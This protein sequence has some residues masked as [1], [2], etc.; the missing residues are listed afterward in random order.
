MNYP[1]GEPTTTRPRPAEDRRTDPGT[2][3]LDATEA[4]DVVPD[5]HAFALCLT[6]DV[7]RPYYTYQSVADA[8]RRRSATP[9]RR[10]VTGPNPYWQ[11]DRIVDL[12]SELGVRSS[13][14]FLR[15]PP[16]WR[17]GGPR[18]WLDPTNW[19]EHLGRY[20]VAAPALADAVRTLDE[21]GWEV[22]LHGSRRAHRDR[23]RLAAEKRRLETVLGHEVA[24]CR[25]H[26]LALSAATWAHQRDVGLRYDATLGSATSVGFAHGYAP[27]RPA[28]DDFLVFPLTAMEVAL[29]DPGDDFAGA[30]AACDRLCEEAASNDA[31]ATVLWH[32]RYFSEFAFPGYRRLYRHLVETALDA[33]A[34]VG[35]IGDLYARAV[36]DPVPGPSRVDGN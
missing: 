29:P 3:T 16:L 36:D 17:M 30:A 28:D 23:D 34:W 1:G 5:G 35:P 33:G 21:G 26:H 15:E 13:C 7:D 12:E 9:L 24:G 11:F 27:L 20:D 6:H 8:V 4:T 2:T 32:P 19:V 14:Y 10:A 22:G 18:A 31:V 25:H